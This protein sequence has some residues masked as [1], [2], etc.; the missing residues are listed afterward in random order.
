MLHIAKIR[1]HRLDHATKIQKKKKKLHKSREPSNSLEQDYQSV[2]TK[3]N[4][5]DICKDKVKAVSAKIRLAAIADVGKVEWKN[6]SWLRCNRYI[7]TR[8]KVN[9]MY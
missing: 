9:Q 8:L 2:D 7:V 5:E 1:M 3:N 4:E 6:M